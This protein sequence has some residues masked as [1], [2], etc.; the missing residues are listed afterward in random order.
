LSISCCQCQKKYFLPS[1][2]IEKIEPEQSIAKKRC[3][4]PMTLLSPIHGFSTRKKINNLQNL[5]NIS[6]YCGK[7]PPKTNITGTIPKN[8]IAP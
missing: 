6:K 8:L 4:T 5:R 1:A 3:E 7:K 2:S